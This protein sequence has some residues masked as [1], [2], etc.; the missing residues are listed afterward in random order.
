MNFKQRMKQSVGINFGKLSIEKT[1]ALAP[2]ASVADYP[3]RMMC[4]KFGASLLIGELASAKGLCY[5]DRKTAELLTVTREE[6]PMGVQLFGTDPVFM[7]K[8]CKLAAAYEPDFIDLNMGCP[9]PKVVNLGAGSALMKT[10]TLAAQIVSA[11]VD[12]VDLPITVKMRRGFHAGEDIAV[13]FACLMEEAGASMITVHGRTR[14]QM[15]HPSADWGCIKAVKQAVQ[16]P[17]I[18]NGDVTSPQLAK[19]MYDETGCDLVMIGRGS[20]GR[21]WIFEEVA[22]YLKDGTI[23]PEKP[24]AER[25]ELLLEHVS[26]MCAQ[27]PEKIAMREARKLVGWYLK[28]LHGAATFRNQASS[29]ECYNDLEQLIAQVLQVQ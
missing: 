11:C 26:L 17:V 21:P 25:F 7:A 15:Y 2:M 6:R 29:L 28:G 13:E 22:A 14:S 1:A 16:V 27:M 3:Y 12:A 10:P 24:A 19:Q 4:K 23:L 9:V 8:A 5:S 18:G 20:Y